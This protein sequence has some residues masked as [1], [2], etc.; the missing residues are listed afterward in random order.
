MN[1]RPIEEAR[2]ADLRRTR[3]AMERAAKRARDLAVRTGTP[4][5]VSRNGVIEYVK[6]ESEKVDRTRL[7]L[8]GL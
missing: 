5:V 3:P 8:P 7:S 2:D 1:T 4:I 6:P